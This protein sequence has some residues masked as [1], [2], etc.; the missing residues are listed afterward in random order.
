[1]SNVL[2]VI[3]SASFLNIICIVCAV[4]ATDN[5]KTIYHTVQLTLS[6]IITITAF[7]LIQDCLKDMDVFK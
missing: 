7:Y 6:D 5:Y 2:K 1:M 4:N 3:S